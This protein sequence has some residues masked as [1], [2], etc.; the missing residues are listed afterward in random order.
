M[1]IFS[2]IQQGAVRDFALALLRLG[3]GR[4]ISSCSLR[5]LPGRAFELAKLQ[6]A[7]GSCSSRGFNRDR[8]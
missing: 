2:P 3:H 7:L 1:G 4:Q 6:Q 5:I 8:L